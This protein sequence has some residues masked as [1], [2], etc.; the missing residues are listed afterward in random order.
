M[1]VAEISG[2]QRGMFCSSIVEK[3]SKS[4]VWLT[5]GCLSHREDEVQK[6]EKLHAHHEVTVIRAAEK[7]VAEK[8]GGLVQAFQEQKMGRRN[9]LACTMECLHAP[10]LLPPFISN[11][12]KEG[13]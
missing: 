2:E 1:Q 9:A 4:G 8:P 3:P 6:Y 7:A 11:T 12:V 10:I 13:R 5:K